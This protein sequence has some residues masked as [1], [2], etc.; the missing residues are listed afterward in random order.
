MCTP[1]P[2]NVGSGKFGRPWERMH[3]A[4][5]RYCP[6]SCGVMC[7]LPS[8]P[9]PPPGIS[10]LHA[11]CADLNRGLPEMAGLIAIATLT[12]LP[13]VVTFGSGKSGTPCARTHA[14]N[15]TAWLSG[16]DSPPP[17]LP[18]GR[19]A[20][21]LVVEVLDACDP[22]L[23]TPPLGELPPQP[24]TSTPAAISPARHAA[25]RQ[26]TVVVPRSLLYLPSC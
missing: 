9:G 10:F 20:V 14:E 4:A 25:P 11:C 15:A 3:A 17:E 19:G 21:V 22:R 8:P 12:L 24:A 13:W 1:P 2:E 6:C 7:W 5:F 18:A 16:E 23:A 26:R